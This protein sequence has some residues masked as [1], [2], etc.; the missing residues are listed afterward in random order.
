[1]KPALSGRLV[2]VLDR[3]VTCDTRPNSVPVRLVNRTGIVDKMF[4]LRPAAPVSANHRLA[5]TNREFVLDTIP[6]GIRGVFCF[7]VDWRIG[8]L[9][10]VVQPP[11]MRRK[12]LE[13]VLTARIITKEVYARRPR[14][15]GDG[16]AHRL[17]AFKHRP[18]TFAP[19]T[20]TKTVFREHLDV[21]RVRCIGPNGRI[22]GLEPS[23]G[24]FD[25]LFGV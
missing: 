2:V 25:D 22:E 3:V 24:D 1:M 16:G 9:A 8:G 6:N 7:V 14:C 5:R 18:R 23:L 4:F 10:G 21:R 11:T 12:A 13:R 20:H 19:V 17:Y 15:R